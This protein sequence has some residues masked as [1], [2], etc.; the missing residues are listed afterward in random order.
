M[1]MNRIDVSE[2]MVGHTS[3]GGPGRQRRLDDFT[4][5]APCS[6]TV[7]HQANMAT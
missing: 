3:R 6:G 5:T 2:Q 4:F 1:S 7:N